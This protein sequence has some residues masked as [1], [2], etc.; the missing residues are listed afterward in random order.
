[1]FIV[2]ALHI[3]PWLYAFAFSAKILF[4][5]KVFIYCVLKFSFFSAMNLSFL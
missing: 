2:I 1:M 4:D 3:V 5:S